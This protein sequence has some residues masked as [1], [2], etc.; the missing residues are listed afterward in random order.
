MLDLLI[1]D[2]LLTVYKFS[3]NPIFLYDLIADSMITFGDGG[4]QTVIPYNSDFSIQEKYAGPTQCLKKNLPPNNYYNVEFL[5]TKSYCY[6]YQQI[7]TYEISN[8]LTKE[9]LN[10][11]KSNDMCHTGIG[12]IEIQSP[13]DTDNY[14]YSMQKSNGLMTGGYDSNTHLTN[15]NVD[16]VLS[17]LPNGIY[18]ITRICKSI[19]NCYIREKVEIISE[20][21]SIQSITIN[22]SYSNKNNGTVE[23]K[24][25]YNTTKPVTFEIV[26]TQLSNNNGIFSNLSPNDYQIKITIADRMCPVTLLEKFTINS[27]PTPKPVDPSKDQSDDPSDELSTSTL[28]QVNNLLLLF[29]ILIL[30]IIF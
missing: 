13:L 8:G 12:K 16:Q 14:Y 22:H 17:N 15:D 23:I 25:N 21:P 7:G 20:N 19:L 29:I 24:L 3:N 4:N 18:N 11:K 5:K 2:L 30:T 26:N 6:S 28:I 10:I 1:N 9:S 27:I